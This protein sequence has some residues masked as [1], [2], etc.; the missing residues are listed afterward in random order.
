MQATSINIQPCNIGSAE[1][2]NQRLK[3]IDYVCPELSSLNENWTDGHTLSEHLNNIKVR[4]KELTG[5]K[6][7]A[8]ATPIREGVIV[9]SKDTTMQELKFFA[10]EVEKEWG[11]KTLQIH[12]HRDEGYMKSRDWK[13]NL[14]AHI[15]FDWTNHETG[16]SIKLNK[17]DM[18]DMQT[19]LSRC[20]GMERG[21]SSDKKHLNAIQYKVLKEEERVLQLEQEKNN[22][23]KEIGNIESIQKAIED[24]NKTTEITIRDIEVQ[25]IN[26]GLFGAKI[27][28][29]QAYEKM[30]SKLN[31]L[32]LIPRLENDN[33][34]NRVG[35]LELENDSLRKRIDTLQTGYKKLLNEIIDITKTVKEFTKNSFD[36]F[37]N[38]CVRYNT[39]HKFKKIRAIKLSIKNIFSMFFDNEVIEVKELDIRLFKV[40]QNSF[41]EL[42][43][44]N[45]PLTRIEEKLDM[46]ELE[47]REKQKTLGRKM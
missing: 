9:I 16:K 4:T 38:S 27:D 28:Q 6:L 19:L 17:Q 39:E 22:R 1:E 34:K 44:N 32:E 25:C 23:E 35:S 14:H 42:G 26:R 24:A 40:E 10:N 29:K 21:H 15:I 7:Q 47:K 45:I 3:P 12:I 33:L 20:L 30:K 41:P 8:K 2:H 18:C 31:S 36:K 5:R 11:I 46:Q 13:P 43:I 37:F